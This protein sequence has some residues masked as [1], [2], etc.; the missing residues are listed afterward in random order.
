ML[1]WGRQFPV[2]FPSLNS[3]TKNSQKAF[4]N[5]FEL[6]KG[7]KQEGGWKG[8][9][10]LLVIMFVCSLIGLA[11]HLFTPKGDKLSKGDDATVVVEKKRKESGGD[12]VYHGLPQPV[13]YGAHF[14]GNDAIVYSNYLHGPVRLSLDRM[15]PERLLKYNPDSLNPIPSHDYRY[16]A[17]CRQVS[18]HVTSKFNAT[19]MISIFDR[20]TYAL[21]DRSYNGSAPTELK[22][23]LT[24]KVGVTKI[25]SET[26]RFFRWN[27]IGYDYVFWQ[28]GHLYYSE[29]PESLTSVRI[30]IEGLNR[31]H[32]IS[33]RSYGVWWSKKGK[34]LAF[35][36]KEKKEEKSILMV[37]Y[38][39]GESYPS[40]MEQKYAKTHEKQ[41]PT[42]ILFVWDKGSRELKQMDVQLRNRTAYHIFYGAEWVVIGDEEF[43][44]VF[45]ADRLQTHISVTICDHPS[46]F[47]KLIFEHKYP[48]RTWPEVREF[49]SILSSDNAI[50]ILL[51]RARADGNSYQHIA[52]LTIQRTAGKGARA[53]KWAK[54]SFLSI[55]NFDVVKLNAYDKNN[56]TIYFTASAPSPLN[57][58]LYS[59]MGSP[60]TTDAWKCVSCGHSNCTY[61]DNQLT[62]NFKHILTWCKGPAVPRYYLGDIVGGKVE[63]LVEILK[64]ESYEKEL[65]STILPSIIRDTVPLAQGYE[66][67]VKIYLP[68]NQASRSSSSSLPVLLK[69]YAGPGGPQMASDEC[70]T[71]DGFVEFLV[72]SRKYAVVMIDGRGSNGRGWKYR[73]AFHGALGTVEIEDQIEGIRQ[74]IRKYPFLDAHRLSVFGWSYGG[75]AAALM[76][77]KAPESFFKCAISVA[78][79]AN[80]LYYN[81][82]YS[83]KYMGNAEKS[84]YDASDIT[85]NVS[86]FKKTRLLLL[87]GL[88]DENVHFQH[89]ALFIEALQRNDIDFDVMVYPN[90][91][92]FIT[93]EHL[94][95]KI[96]SFLKQ[97]AKRASLECHIGYSIIRGSTIGEETKT[98]EKETDY[99][100]NVTAPLLF[101]STIQKAGCNTFICQFFSNGC[102]EREIL[103]I[104]VK[105]CCC[106]DE[107][108]CNRGTMTGLT[109]PMDQ[110][111]EVALKELSNIVG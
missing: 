53:M 28:D 106:M 68:P 19:F 15:E 23:R 98:C 9:A 43:L 30:S 39:E 54:S 56:D 60:T 48:S 6:G 51:P 66:A 97:C 57:R 110:R 67:N 93:S 70:F 21:L 49:S 102:Y 103:G 29:S 12:K 83:E 109:E 31:Q 47:C 69:V 11:F 79:V 99:C 108:L 78:P 81:T 55:G 42:F 17:F 33:E 5:R 44:V 75:F 91:D 71:T 80:F 72:T 77:E 89:S 36:S 63:N 105:I 10:T 90:K 37:G 20:E 1:Y 7:V 3:S 4:G 27:P 52:K 107:D 85:K 22:K 92:H 96:S 74:V 18:F 62:S 59:T 34:K 40:V 84:V 104:P 8:I 16:Y 88:Y 94:H 64:D 14:V 24:Y 111:E 73:G 13:N 2:S 95:K 25:G 87:H 50:Y 45:W 76:S 65:D 35:L 100:Y 32:E 82:A 86:N 61:Q 38:T 26:Q 41:I 58:H 101:V 46:G